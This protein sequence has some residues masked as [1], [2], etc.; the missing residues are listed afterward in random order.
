MEWGG[1]QVDVNILGALH[2]GYSGTFYCPLATWFEEPTHWKRPWCW[3]RLKAG[4]EGDDRGWDGWMAS[5]T[6]WACVW[7]SSGSWWRTG[8]PGVLQSMDHKE[9]DKLYLNNTMNWTTTSSPPFQ[10][11]PTL[12][13]SLLKPTS[14][15]SFLGPSAR[16]GGSSSMTPSGVLLVFLTPSESQV[17]SS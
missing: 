17:G 10:V 13:G 11:S 6:R 15:L 1:R 9:L 12:Q 7:A 2:G 16:A 4:G 5:P 3:E 8:R 14:S